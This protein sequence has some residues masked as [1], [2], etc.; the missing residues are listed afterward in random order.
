MESQQKNKYVKTD[1]ISHI[2]LRPDMYA[3]STIWKTKPQ[4]VATKNNLIKLRK[5]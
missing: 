4:F 5:I 2:R 3:G 1:P